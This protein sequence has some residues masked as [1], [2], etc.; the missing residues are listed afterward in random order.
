MT[1]QT[2]RQRYKAQDPTTRKLNKAAQLAP[3]VPVPSTRCVHLGCGHVALQHEPDDGP[4][5]A[6]CGCPAYRRPA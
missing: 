4:C 3:S 5:L 6:G 2:A 1:H